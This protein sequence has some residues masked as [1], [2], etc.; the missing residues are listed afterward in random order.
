MYQAL[1]P[2]DRKM[3]KEQIE[4]VTLENVLMNQMYNDLGFKAGDRLLI[5]VESQSKWSENIL[6]RI[7][8]YL[9]QTIQEEIAEKEQNVYSSRKITLPEMEFYMIYIGNE[10]EQQGKPAYIS[11][12]ESFYEGRSTALELK[13]RVLYG[14]T[15]GDIVWQYV[16]FTKICR[17]QYKKYGRT[18]KAVEETIRLCM[19]Q[20]VLA[21]FLKGRKKEVMDAM[22][23]L[24]D[25]DYIWN[26]ALKE[27]RDEGLERGLQRGRMEGEAE[28][29][30]RGLQ[31]GRLENSQ[32]IAVRMAGLGFSVEEI[33]NVLDEEVKTVQTWLNG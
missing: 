6:V 7:L 25:Q 20:N 26:A 13:V 15:E 28:G 19:E 18:K 16:Q 2:E 3:T 5:L 1:H 33:A 4:I 22:N 30:Q 27:S 11:L 9:S 31:R 32:K 14:E 10:N 8:L 12:S 24:Y 29:L 23:I 17:S 21:E